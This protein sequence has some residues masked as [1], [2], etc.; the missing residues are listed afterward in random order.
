[1][2][3]AQIADAKMYDANSNHLCNFW[4]RIEQ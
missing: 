4:F 2:N 3:L 1:M